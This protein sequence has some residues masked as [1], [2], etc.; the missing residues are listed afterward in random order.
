M[1][2]ILLLT[3]GGTI[4]C[5]EGANG[6]TP[7]LSGEALLEYVPQVREYARLRV[8]PL[9]NKD[10]TNMEPRDWLSIADAIFD[11]WLKY[12]GIV[13]L[14]GTDTMAY[15]ASAVSFMTLGIGIPVVFTGSQHPVGQPES[16]AP[17]NLADAICT[18][19]RC[20]L[21]GVLLTFDGTVFNGCCVSKV[22][23]SE[24]HAFESCGGTPVGRI[25]HGALQITAPPRRDVRTS[26][27]WRRSL[28][29]RVLFLKITPGMDGAL[30]ELATLGHYPIVVLEGFGLGGIPSGENGLLER[31]TQLHR[32]GILVVVTTQCSRGRC[33]MTVYEAGQA[34]LEHGALCSSVISKEA[35]LTKLM[36]ILAQTQAPEEIEQ[37]L[38]HDFCGELGT[39]FPQI[40]K[41]GARVI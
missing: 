37:L 3:T 23:T 7:T 20:D 6:Y 5:T 26:L 30:L 4:A 14:H 17:R 41:D 9:L 18:A 32:R 36:W 10:S 19:C 12:D 16:D 8:Q 11:H 27:T 21:G 13:V 15:S 34:A 33:D 38:F 39:N 29:S 35:L 25:R 22:S 24:L 28:D 40:D 31:I 2:N 1:K